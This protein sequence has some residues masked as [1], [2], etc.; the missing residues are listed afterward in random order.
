VVLRL[1]F[2]HL[3]ALAPGEFGDLCILT[4]GPDGSEPLLSIRVGSTKPDTMLKAVE[5]DLTDAL[6]Q[7]SGAQPG[8]L[9]CYVPESP[10]VRGLNTLDSGIAQMT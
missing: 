9:V 4:A 10:S 6:G 5:E 8:R 3:P 7:F 2:N 1:S